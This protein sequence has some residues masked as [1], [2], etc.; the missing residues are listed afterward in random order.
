L[1][2]L[3]VITK[4]IK[5]HCGCA[6][7]NVPLRP[8][9]SSCASE[10]SVWP[11]NVL[12][13]RYWGLMASGVWPRIDWWVINW[14]RAQCVHI[15]GH[16]WSSIWR[17]HDRSKRRQLCVQ[18]QQQ[19]QQHRCGNLRCRHCASWSVRTLQSGLCY[20]WLLRLAADVWVLLNPRYEKMQ[21]G[22]SHST[23]FQYSSVR[24]RSYMWR[25][26]HTHINTYL[27]DHTVSLCTLRN[28]AKKCIHLF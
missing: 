5:T 6:S 28:V 10:R 7:T 4:G 3:R 16:D 9:Y 13:P 14:G 20:W 2:Q 24:Q 25:H 27:C 26:T 21:N 22:W 18:R 15:Q 1:T 19:Q 23:W 12:K 17:H 11:T 8:R